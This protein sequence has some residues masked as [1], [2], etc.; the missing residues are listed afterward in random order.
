VLGRNEGAAAARESAETTQLG[1]PQQLVNH[2]QSH[3]LLLRLQFVPHAI[4][5]G[6]LV[7]L[8]AIPQLTKD[9][10]H[11]ENRNRKKNRCFDQER[12]MSNFLCY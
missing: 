12:C 6:R 2:P 11:T 7:Q 1:P 4:A 5:V 9:K 10:R 3:S 8:V